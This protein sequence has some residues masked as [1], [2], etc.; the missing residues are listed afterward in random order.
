ME[1]VLLVI[2]VILIVVVLLQSNKAS[3]ASQIITG[4]NSVLLGKSKE[5]GFEKFITRLT[6]ALGFAF[7]I[8][9]MVLSV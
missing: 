7:I 6:Y 1:K 9:S 3:D 2:S 4:G 8:L 5:R